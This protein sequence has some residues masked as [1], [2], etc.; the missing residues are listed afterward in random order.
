VQFDQ[1]ALDALFAAVER[2]GQLIVSA[3]EGTEVPVSSIE[4]LGSRLTRV[5]RGETN[6]KVAEPLD[7]FELGEDVLSVLTELRR[8]TACA[9]T[10][11][12]AASSTCCAP[13]STCRTSDVGLAEIDATVKKLG[14]VITKLPS[15]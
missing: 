3:A 8:S 14:E 12:R 15:S 9:K 4:D 1:A 11:R 5:A 7:L 2:A 10:S 13:R 6:A